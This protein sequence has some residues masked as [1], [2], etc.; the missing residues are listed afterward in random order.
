MKQKIMKLISIWIMLLSFTVSAFSKN[1]EMYQGT[2][3]KLYGKIVDI[4]E[5]PIIGATLQVINGNSDGTIT[6]FDGNFELYALPDNLVK[7]SFVGYESQ[8]F[9]ASKLRGTKVV[10]KEES[11]LLDEV[12]VVGF[13]TQKKVNLTGA[14][15]TVD[16]KTMEFRPVQ[17]VAQALQ[18]V[19]PG[20]NI[21]RNTGVMDSQPS[22]NIRGMA[23]IGD[24][25]SGSPLILIDGIDGDMNTL[26]PD[27]IESISVLKDASSAAIYGS[28][29]A[30]GVIL[31][32]TK[33]GAAQ[34]PVVNYKNSFRWSLPM[35]LQH[36]ADSYSWALFMNDADL[37]GNYFSDEHLNRILQYQRGEITEPYLV[38]DDGKY[39]SCWYGGSHA[40]VDWGTELMKDAAFS[41]E[42]QASI[43]GGSDKVNYYVSADYL[44]MDGMLKY[45]EDTYKRLSF[46]VS[47]YAKLWNFAD[48]SYTTRFSRIDYKKPSALTDGAYQN[49]GR[50]QWPTFPVYD[51]NGNLSAESSYAYV[52]ATT[53]DASTSKKSTI[54]QQLKLTIE[55]IKDLKI[56]GE[57]GYQGRYDQYHEH[58]GKQYLYDVNNNPY[59]Y[60]ESSSVSESDYFSDKMTYS[61]YANYDKT[62]E[63]GHEIATTIGVQAETFSDRKL[64]ASRDGIIVLSLPNIDNTTG[65]DKDGQVKEP[66]VNGRREKWATAGYF[67]RVGYNYKGRYLVEFN[68]R[69][70]G[71]SRFRRDSRWVFSP[72]FSAGWNIANEEF[73]ENIKQQISQLKLRVSYGQL[74]NQNTNSYYPTYL[75]MPVSANSG[76]WLVNGNKTNTANTPSLVSPDLTWEKVKT[77]DFG[78]DIS[79][80]D[81]RFLATFDWYKRNTEDMVGPAPVLPTILGIAPPKMNNT[82]LSTKG[83][84][85]SLSWQDKIKDFWYKVG[86]SLSDDQTIITDYPSTVRSVDKYFT[87]KHV[88]DIYGLSTVGIAK[89][90]KEMKNH[91]VSLPNGGQNAIGNGWTAGDIMYEDVNGDGKVDKGDGTIDNLGDLIR[92]GNDQPRYRIGI[93]AALAWK[94][95]DMSA[96]FQGV[97]KQD[98]SPG[99]GNAT[100]YGATWDIWWS[101]CLKQH[102]DYFRN[103]ENHPLGVN[104]DS[105]YPR[106]LFGTYKN[107]EHQTRYVQS[108][109]YLRLKNL[110]LGYTLPEKF[111]KKVCISNLRFYISGENIVTITSLTDMYDP[112][113][114]WGG[115]Y[116]TVY[117][118]SK[119]WSFGIS[120][121]F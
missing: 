105:Y 84:E 104:I 83:W 10:L 115:Y 101:Q 43:K 39:V 1:D 58:Y 62:W 121:N 21:S 112:E 47:L 63:K 29:A 46:N 109:A 35:G 41:H 96:F 42:H 65:L 89:T 94:G 15:A 103:D 76:T 119:T 98:Y 9:E 120:A 70:D 67:A 12:V 106:P 2:K 61:L 59:P 118:L 11:K 20:L 53:K 16:S 110:Q 92:I 7:I 117:P 57:I 74:A 5:D 79:A 51:N 68:G 71:T 95:F 97:L 55:P 27:D 88:G 52:H 66:S 85:I 45:G 8:T 54:T 75:V 24:G 36:Q 25:S 81:N 38:G 19:S 69:Y 93:N 3:I 72:S 22:V 90:D 87:G 82:S 107:Q 32:T 100:F 17:N 91:L 31:I 73:W 114:M 40:N 50:Q 33:K 60:N 64:G 18:G 48:L 77:I 30:F 44:D 80:F 4:N 14:V 78:F 23:T 108:A 99:S 102:L 13:G 56:N 28:R 111:T 26:N 49:W 86:I 116:G 113:T 37:T 6:D 34:K